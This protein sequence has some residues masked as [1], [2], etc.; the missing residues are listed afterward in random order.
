M[1]GEDAQIAAELGV[2]AVWVSNHGGRQLDTL[3]ATIEVLPEIVS[4]VSGRCEVY[5]DGGICR[6]TDVFKALALGANMVFAGRAVV[7]GLVMD[8]QA[9]VTKGLEI[10]K[11]ELDLAMALAGTPRIRDITEDF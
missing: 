1:T 2:D 11:H 9:G 4:A 10:L 6:G 7:W 5:I 3:F 8:G